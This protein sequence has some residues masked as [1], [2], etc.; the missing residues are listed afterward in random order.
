[1][2]RARRKEC[3]ECGKAFAA[4]RA[5]MHCSHACR[6]SAKRCG[7]LEYRRGLAA[8]PERHAA[9]LAYQGALCAASRSGEGEKRRPNPRR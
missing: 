8:D 3:K 6:A 2:G 5:V 7:A 9:K 4:Q 1:M